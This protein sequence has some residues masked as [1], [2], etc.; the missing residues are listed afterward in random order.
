[1]T[2]QELINKLLEECAAN[3]KDPATTD[4]VMEDLEGY[5]LSVDVDSFGGNMFEFKVVLK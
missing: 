5:H 3:E 2:V 1:M 4:V